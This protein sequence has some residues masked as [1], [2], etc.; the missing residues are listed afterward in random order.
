KERLQT[1]CVSD[2][3]VFCF[4]NFSSK[5]AER[6]D[7]FIRQTRAANNCQRIA[8]MFGHNFVETFSGE[9]NRLVPSRGDK[10]PALLV[11]NQRRANAVFVID[12]RMPETAF[13]A[14]E[15]AVMA[16][17]VSIAR[18]DAH[19]IVSARAQS[20]PA[21]LRPIRAGP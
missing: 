8:A 11:T 3:K 19:Q 1:E 13:D 6:V 15:L 21:T 14:Q 17:Y 4:D 12:E 10:T 5:L 2:T 20:P 7:R 9:S 18:D 16:V